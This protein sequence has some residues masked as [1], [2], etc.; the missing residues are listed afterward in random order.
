MGGTPQTDRSAQFK[1]RSKVDTLV[2]ARQGGSN[3][4][5]VRA[6]LHAMGV[7]HIS[8]VTSHILAL[9][10]LRGRNFQLVVFETESLGMPT[11]EFVEQAA[12]MDPKMTMLAVSCQPRID[13][14]FSLLKAGARGFI[15]PPFTA[16]SFESAVM[17]AAEGPPFSEV[18]LDAPDRN[19][20]L[21]AVVLNNFYR[22]TVRM[23]QSRKFTSALAEVERYRMS[24]HESM[25]L[26]RLF[27]E[28]GDESAFVTRIQEECTARSQIASSRLGRMRKKLAQKRMTTG[29]E[30]SG[31]DA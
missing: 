1:T 4:L 8:A 14:V 28:G 26:A 7:T 10:R 31:S 16:E 12:E 18:V 30:D 21:V 5:Q 11:T 23:R 17:R 25:E 27:C 3:N 20:A 15:I 19:A 24:F 9:E 22:L 29:G 6:A 2:V 13:E